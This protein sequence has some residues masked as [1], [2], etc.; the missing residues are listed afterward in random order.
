ME[1]ALISG[2]AFTKDESE[3]IIKGVKDQWSAS[4][5]LGPI[6]DANIEVDMIVQN[7][8]S[9]G[10]A[11]FTFNYRNSLN[12]AVKLLKNIRK[13]WDIKILNLRET[14][15]KCRLLAWE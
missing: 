15:L 3:I 14:L 9:D 4:K 6:G 1:G 13:A 5:I 2:I 8:G 7:V 11:D 12:K 10:L